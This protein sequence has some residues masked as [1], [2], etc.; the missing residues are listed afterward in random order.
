MGL[1]N[2]CKLVPSLL[3]GCPS[4]YFQNVRGRAKP[5]Q[6]RQFL[7]IIEDYDLTMKEG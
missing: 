6:V 5:Y 4:P 1:N 7:K 3:Q 2:V